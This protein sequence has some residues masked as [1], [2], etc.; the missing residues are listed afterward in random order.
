MRLT[1][2][3]T[4]VI[5]AAL[6]GWH[7]AHAPALRAVV[8]ATAK[9]NDRLVVPAPALLEAYAVMTRL[10]APHRISPADA[11]ELVSGSFE[12]RATLVALTESQTWRFLQ[13]A[14]ASGIAGGRAYDGQILRCARKAGATRLLT[15]DRRDFARLDP[16][17]I[18]IVVPT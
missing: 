14:A 7:E 13:D 12:R 3:D 2:L 9:R 6:L 15:L 1:A 17:A 18:E 10:P 16:G 8:A 11:L 4:S 5:V